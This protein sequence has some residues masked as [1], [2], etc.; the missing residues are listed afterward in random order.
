MRASLMGTYRNMTDDVINAD[1]PADGDDLDEF[2][3]EWRE[4]GYEPTVD[5]PGLIDL[6]GASYHR[7]R[8][9]KTDT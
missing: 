4:K 6:D 1:W 9:V 3:A 5:A 8:M 2:L 7:Y